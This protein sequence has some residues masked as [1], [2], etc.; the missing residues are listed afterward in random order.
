V[1]SPGALTR[2]IIERHVKELLLVEE[3]DLERAVHVL[4]EQQHLVAEGAG[5]AALAC[6][7]AYPEKFRGKTVALV[8]S[9]GN[10]DARLLAQVLM[11]GLI[12][13]G[14]VVT[15]RVEISD[16]PEASPRG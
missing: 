14:R 4:V 12:Q 3:D 16:Q 11:R 15:L 10:I 13:D 5:G 1:K 2:A 7:M 9:G 6:L 8:I